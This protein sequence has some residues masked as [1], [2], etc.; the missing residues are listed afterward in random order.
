V[1]NARPVAS[2]GT[3]LSF[4]TVHLEGLL[5]SNVPGSKLWQDAARSIAVLLC[6]S[7]V[8]MLRVLARCICPY[9]KQRLV[10][11]CADHSRGAAL[12]LRTFPRAGALLGRAGGRAQHLLHAN[13]GFSLL[14]RAFLEV[15]WMVLL[16]LTMQMAARLGKGDWYIRVP[17]AYSLG[18]ILAELGSTGLAFPAL[19]RQ[20]W[21]KDVLF[22]R[23]TLGGVAPVVWTTD[24]HTV[25]PR[26]ALSSNLHSSPSGS[27]AVPCL[28]RLPTCLPPQG[29]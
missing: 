12:W 17:L 15:P 19:P 10:G 28:L 27:M 26:C 14:R 24:L 18:G 21:I 29:R 3:M 8:Q 20:T 22:N 5:A 9:L 25:R 2:L 13:L 11:D 7:V 1:R 6:L 16:E 4:R 23:S